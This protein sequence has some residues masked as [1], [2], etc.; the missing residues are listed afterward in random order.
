MYFTSAL[1]ELGVY[2]VPRPVT[3]DHM[4]LDVRMMTDSASVNLD[5]LEVF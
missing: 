1:Q 2:V 4:Q 3:V 5:F